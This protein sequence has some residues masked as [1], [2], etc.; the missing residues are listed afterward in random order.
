VGVI[1]P[2]TGESDFLHPFKVRYDEENQEWIIYLPEKSVMDYSDTDS[3]KELPRSES[4]KSASVGDKDWYVINSDYDGGVFVEVIKEEKGDKVVRCGYNVSRDGGGAL[5]A[6]ITNATE[7]SSA[8][9]D[10]RIFSP[11]IL[12]AGEGSEGFPEHFPDNRSLSNREQ[13]D[14]A[15]QPTAYWS[16][17]GFGQFTSET[18]QILGQFAPSS[19]TPIEIPVIKDESSSGNSDMAFLVR[20]GNKNEVNANLLEYRDISFKTC[21][22]PFC[23]VKKTFGLQMVNNVFFFDGEEYTLPDFDCSLI[24][25]KV[26]LVGEKGQTGEWNFHIA[27]SPSSAPHASRIINLPLYDF[28]GGKVTCDYRT[29]FLTLS[30]YSGSSPSAPFDVIITKGASSSTAYVTN[31]TFWFRGEQLTL[32]D[33]SKMDGGGTFYLVGEPAGASEN[34]GQGWEF[35]VRTS[36]S[37]NAGAINIKLYD[38]SDGKVKMDYRTTFLT[39]G[40][41]GGVEIEE[42]EKNVHLQIEKTSTGY[43]LSVPDIQAN[44]NGGKGIKVQG[45]NGS[46]TVINTGITSAKGEENESPEI[47]GDV[48]FCGAEG[49]GLTFSTIKGIEIGEGGEEVEEGE[50]GNKPEIFHTNGRVIVDL[51]GRAEDE[52]WG[53]HD[54]KRSKDDNNSVKFFGT[55]DIELTEQGQ[56]ISKEIEIVTGVHTR[57]DNGVVE[58]T[59]KKM[60]ITDGLITS[61]EDMDGLSLAHKINVVTEIKKGDNGIDA[62]IMPVKVLDPGVGSVECVIEMEDVDVVS[63]VKYENPNFYKDIKKV[64]S[65]SVGSS[66]TSTVFTTT[67]LSAEVSNG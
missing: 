43:K 58:L 46:V 26:Y 22:T 4:M 37:S 60:V 7:E 53:I 20:S 40:S 9:V 6:I 47:N 65:I 5:V 64:R 54:F 12:S 18:N 23:L 10:Q 39:L 34:G 11:I 57:E 66:E 42:G 59:R 67:P 30:S 1:D 15:S 35:S 14:S 61:L 62:T 50:E 48:L 36:S 52:V 31:C 29:T 25:G 63:D 41:E 45:N 17:M 13:S 2:D 44:I 55:G 16:I 27:S 32:P 21:D 49:S 28:S 24:S 8:K 51:V 33:S 19:K 56:G 38:I 3:F